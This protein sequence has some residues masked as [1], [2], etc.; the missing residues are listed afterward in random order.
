MNKRIKKPVSVVLTRQEAEIAMNEL[1]QA[2]NTLRDANAII[3]GEKLKIDEEHAPWLANVKD[4]IETL[5][6][7]LQEWAEAN[8]GEFAGRK[9][10]GFTSGT[11]GFRTGQLAL[12][13]LGRAWDWDK[14][15]KALQALLPAFVRNVPEIDK[16]SVISQRKILE[17]HLAKCGLKVSQGETFF[18]E[19]KLEKLPAR[20]TEPKEAA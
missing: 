16:V 8:P 6:N 11:I 20:I 5:T 1:A 12:R 13:L 2:V 9:S 18:V 3:D 19:P 10:L 14:A 7:K 15:T 4:Q 17:P